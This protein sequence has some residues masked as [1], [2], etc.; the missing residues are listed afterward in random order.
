MRDGASAVGTEWT[1]LIVTREM[2]A[3]EGLGVAECPGW[4]QGGGVEGSRMTPR[5]L[6]PK[7]WCML[8]SWPR[9]TLGVEGDLSVT[10][11]GKRWPGDLGLAG[12]ALEEKQ[13]QESGKPKPRH[14]GC[15]LWVG[16]V[17]QGA[18]LVREGAVLAP[19]RAKG[20]ANQRGFHWPGCHSPWKEG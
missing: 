11:L 5:F 1:C 19:F 4:W 17:S 6:S 2:D 8:G 3:I 16:K 14:A 13:L 7:T 20:E 18:K 12:L 9:S 10:C 15:N